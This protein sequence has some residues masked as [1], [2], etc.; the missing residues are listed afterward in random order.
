[1]HFTRVV[2]R[3]HLSQPPLSRHIKDLEQELEVTLFQQG[4]LGSL[5]IGFVGALTYE[6][7]PGLLRRYR[8]QMP[9]QPTAGSFAACAPM[10]VSPPGSGMK[11]P[12]PRQCWDWSPSAWG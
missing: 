5:T 12:A 9:N 8:T 11:L 1:L 10:P 7:L 4:E 6:F 2:Q 3:L